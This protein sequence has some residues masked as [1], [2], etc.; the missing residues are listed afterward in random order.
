MKDRRTASWMQQNI[1]FR[2]LELNE[3]NLLE[4]IKDICPQMG[5]VIPGKGQ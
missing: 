1:E 2:V 4:G 3:E 5:R